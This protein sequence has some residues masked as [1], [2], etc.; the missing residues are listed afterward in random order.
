MHKDS[1]DSDADRAARAFYGQSADL[2]AAQIAE[3]CQDDIRLF[4][5][6]QRVRDQY[7]QSQEDQAINRRHSQA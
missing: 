1:C 2:F 7:L 6:F 3:I 4:A 5:V